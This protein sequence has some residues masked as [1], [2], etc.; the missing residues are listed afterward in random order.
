MPFR[1]GGSLASSQ[2]IDAQAAYGAMT[3]R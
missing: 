3:P 1:G 2:L